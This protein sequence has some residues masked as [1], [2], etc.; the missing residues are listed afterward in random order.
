MQRT[1]KVKV[2]KNTLGVVVVAYGN[3][4]ATERLLRSLG[5]Q[6]GGGDEVALIDN[7][8]K[9]R[10]AAMARKLGL[11]TYVVESKNVGFAAGC[12]KG[13]TRLSKKPDIYLCM[14]YDAQISSNFV[15]EMRSVDRT[16]YGAWMPLIL[17]PDG[18]VNSAGNVV[19]ISGLSWC[20]G[21]LEQPRG[22]DSTVA[23]TELSGACFAVSR[24]VWRAV[25]GMPEGYFLYYEDTDLSA[26]LILRGVRSA[27]VGGTHI[28]HDYDFAKGGH[29]WL[30]IERNRP[31][32]I[33]RTWPLSVIIILLPAL[34]AF[35]AALWAVALLQGRLTSKMRAMWMTFTALP[36]AL[37]YRRVSQNGRVVSAHKF[38][39]TLT[40]DLNSPVFGR[41][42]RSW[43]VR[44]PMRLYYR[45]ALFAL[46]VL[47]L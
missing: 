38:L 45:S 31:L 12:N 23:V 13:V 15:E 24:D 27:V 41:I 42:G 40:P 35:E 34:L 29:K 28:T 43:M 39:T 9:H 1:H 22:H 6:L 26:Q 18:R 7:H 8:P 32:Y 11:A 33:L 3:P 16:Q 17:L 37:R 30:Y 4:K 20:G 21:Y 36:A 46:R 10:C 19:H 14:N 25:G 2:Q 47:H 44:T 5:D